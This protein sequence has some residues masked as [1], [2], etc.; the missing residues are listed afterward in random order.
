MFRVVYDVEPNL[1]SIGITGWITRALDR[2][3]RVSVVGKPRQILEVCGGKEEEE[4]EEEE[5]K[6]RRRKKK[7]KRR[8]KKKK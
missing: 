7:K 6:K 3:E 4:E 5:E 2:P 1:W 8:R